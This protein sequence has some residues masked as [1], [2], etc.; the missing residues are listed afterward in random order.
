MIRSATGWS[1]NHQRNGYCITKL[2]FSAKFRILTSLVKFQNKIYYWEIYCGNDHC[3]DDD[4]CVRVHVF[5]Q[6][7]KHDSNDVKQL[8]AQVVSY[9]AHSVNR[10]LDVTV[11]STFLPMLVNGTKEKNTVVKISSESALIS[12]L[13]LRA[14]K[15]TLQVCGTIAVISL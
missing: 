7:M 6:T 11:I 5:L 1:V 8:G 15:M 3:F 9:V 14:D 4:R 10:P 12:L 13:R 2:I